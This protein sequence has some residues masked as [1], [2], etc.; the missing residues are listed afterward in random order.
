M[1][2]AHGMP[3]QEDPTG[4]MSLQQ[5]AQM[6]TKTKLHLITRL[7][8]PAAGLVLFAKSKDAA[9][10]SQSILHSPLFEKSY[11]A[12]VEGSLEKKENQLK[13][14]LTHHKKD[15]K[16]FVAEE[17][18]EEFKEALLSYKVLAEYE[19][20]SALKI[21]LDTGRFHQ[22]RAQLAHLG[23]PI[24]GDIKYGA[25]R[26][27]DDRSIHLCAYQMKIQSKSKQ[28]SIECVSQLKTEDTL[29]NET[30]KAI[31]EKA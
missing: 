10:H 27:N 14:Y 24:K 8:R 7:D 13:N 5:L 25:R 26:K 28:K 17:E 6:Y 4:D 23:H 3:V 16:A 30:L 22:I 21:K 19:N 11:I 20:Y 9:A 29:W 31:N 18:S 15:K 12:I 1:D 2:K